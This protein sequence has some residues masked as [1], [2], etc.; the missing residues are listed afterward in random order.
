MEGTIAAGSAALCLT[1]SAAATTAGSGSAFHRFVGSV[2]PL[3]V[4][5]GLTDVRVEAEARAASDAWQT[6]MATNIAAEKVAMDKHTIAVL[7]RTRRWQV[8]EF[9]DM[10]DTVR[11][12]TAKS[13]TPQGVVFTPG[14]CF[15]SMR[16]AKE[17]SVRSHQ[18]VTLT[19]SHELA[20]VTMS[21]A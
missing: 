4:T 16:L 20:R 3:A 21:P 1:A 19:V 7:R 12:V 11:A 17:L 18:F 13:R 6:K 14:C 5:S 2:C 10:T 8:N 9:R 15:H